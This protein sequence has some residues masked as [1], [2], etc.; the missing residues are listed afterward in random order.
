MS[1]RYSKMTAGYEKHF[2]EMQ[3]RKG[4]GATA[5]GQ[6]AREGALEMRR[7]Q[8]V[9]AHSQEGGAGGSSAF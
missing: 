8:Q 3:V 6:G 5:T 7:N 1:P 2:E 9:E 4:Q